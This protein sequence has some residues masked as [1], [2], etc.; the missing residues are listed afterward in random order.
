M[1]HDII[2]N[3]RTKLIDHLRTIMDSSES[4]KFAVGYFFLSGLEG[5]A[6]K[7]DQMKELKLLIGNTTNRETLEQMAEGYRRL[8]LV[9][10]DLEKQSYRRRGEA[11]QMAG[12]AVQNV[13]EAIEVGDQSDAQQAT[14]Q[15]IVRLIEEKRLRVRIYTKGR[16]HA[17]AYIFNYGPIY[18]LYGKVKD[19]EEHGIGVVGSSNLTLS[20]VSHNTELNV[21]VHGNTNHQELTAWFDELWE[22][23]E[24][25]DESLLLEMKQSWALAEVT[26]YEIYLKTLYRLVKD[27]LDDSAKHVTLGSEIE[28]RLADFQRAAVDVVSGMI[29]RHG[30]GFVADVVGLGKS[31]I[32][33]AI[34]K[35]FE[36]QNFRPLIICPAPLVEMWETYN[37]VYALNA[38]VLSNGLLGREDSAA[39]LLDPETG[40]YRDRDFVLIDE[41]HNF[42]SSEANRYLSVK[43]FLDAGGDK[44]VCLLTATPRNS[45]AWDVY[46]QIKLFHPNDKTQIQIDPPDL[47]QFFKLVESG[48]KPLP[49]ILQHVLYRRR[50]NDIVRWYGHDEV[51]GKLLT[52]AT[53]Q[54]YRRGERRA[55]VEVGG[56]KQFFPTRR[57]Q[58]I[59]YSIEDTYSG[60]YDRIRGILGRDKNARTKVRDPNELTY[61]RYGLWHYVLPQKQQQD[62]YKSLHQAGASLRGLIRVLMFKRFESSVYAFRCTIDR[63]IRIHEAF[64]TAMTAGIVPAGEDAQSILYESDSYDDA[65]L[66]EALLAVDGKY[67]LADFNAKKLEEDIEHDVDL[68]KQLRE[69]V[70]PITAR[71]DAKLQELLHRMSTELC[72]GKCLIFTQY[73]DTAEY[74]RDNL[75]D[76]VADGELDAAFASNKSKR[77]IVARF[78]PKANPDLR[79]RVKG[80]ELRVV[81][82]TD[83][84]SEGLN[85][86]DCDR[87]VNYDLHWNPVRLIQR[88]GRIDRIGSEHSE[89]WGYNFLPETGIERNLGLEQVLRDRIR[90]IHESIGEDSR[91]LDSAEQLNEAAMYSIYEGKASALDEV[92]D[93]RQVE[94][95]GTLSE[96]EELLR[97]LKESDPSLF[98]RIASMRDG[99][100]SAR[101][102]D[103]ETAVV[104]CEASADADD[105]RPYQQLFHIDSHGNILSRDIRASLLALAC[106]PDEPALRIPKALNGHVMKIRR[107]FAEEVKHREAELEHSVNLS[108]A[109]RFVL[110][111]LQSM[112]KDVAD[113]VTKGQINLLEEA[114]RQPLSDAVRR[115]LN[116]LRRD[117]STGAR[118]LESLKRIYQRHA[119]GRGSRKSVAGPAKTVVR[120]VCSEALTG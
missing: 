58:T 51:S 7:L 28:S 116:H 71:Q 52:E 18:D 119:L 29:R 67:D 105:S 32:G 4:A 33:A 82:A 107:L 50:R 110:R 86:Q 17:K 47:K 42:R 41:S 3:R 20:G 104:F 103:E 66:I 85:L 68:L 89:I 49:E 61:A 100:R 59:R 13:R 34:V 8:D 40:E 55:Y 23:S 92:D 93:D 91:I 35:R 60:L 98:N 48:D 95:L 45:S 65:G 76:V 84:L 112:F 27:R 72:D 118:L 88:F 94:G 63:L 81:V 75:A 64:I 102:A 56:G 24:D 15:L 46:N 115:E 74:L 12:D 117:K 2:D 5:I 97:A 96:A 69:M 54:E 106:R 57:L 9:Q 25:F 62:R 78:A 6:E 16:L 11:Q 73:A 10:E 39:R 26:P 43:N 70:Q 101:K 21:L 77:T 19:R 1:A 111:E 44:K 113:D 37:E 31:F 90:E 79:K 114:F 87:I 38:R 36:Q 30:G 14:I 109:Q 22:E 53:F 108:P 83:V 99:V 120:V 80:S